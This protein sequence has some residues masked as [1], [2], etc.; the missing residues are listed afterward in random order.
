MFCSRHNASTD[1]FIPGLPGLLTSSRKKS[2]APAA[3]RLMSVM[4]APGP[5]YQ[6]LS[7]TTPR[8]TEVYYWRRRHREALAIANVSQGRLAVAHRALAERFR[9]LVRVAYGAGTERV[10]D[11]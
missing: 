6:I 1:D 7:L 4:A 2:T 5:P 8:E 11:P 10:E 3:Y 9:K